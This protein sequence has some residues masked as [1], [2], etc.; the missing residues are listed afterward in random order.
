MDF[1]QNQDVARKKTGVLV[2][3]F[4]LAVVVIIVSVYVA[5]AAI[6]TWSSTQG[7]HGSAPGL[8]HLWDPALFG[9]VAV[10]VSGLV[11]GGSL[12]KIAALSGGGHT[13]AELLGGRLLNPAEANGP[14]ERKILNVVE[15]MAIASGVPVPPVYLLEEEQG[16][17]AFAAGHAPGDAVIAV[18]SGC[19]RHLSRD[20]LQGVVAHE[21][22]HIL[23]GDMRLNIRLMGVLFGILLI[24]LTG[25]LILRSTDGSSRND[26]RKEGK[27]VLPFIGL[28]LYIIGYS[29]V[30]FGNLIKA[31][32]SRQREFLADASAV[33][34]TRNPDGI[35]GALKKIG[36]LS[37]GSKIEN[38][39]AEEASHLFFGSSGEGFGHFLG[40]LATHPP[41]V[42]R[43]R[44]IDPSFDGD[45]SAVQLTPIESEAESPRP[46]SKKAVSRV[47]AFNPVE[48]I[49]KIGTI[50]PAQLA[51]AAGLLESL[52][53]PLTEAVRDPLSAQAVVFALLL[54]ADESV[55]G[56]QLG[57]LEQHVLPASVRETRMILPEVSRLAPE[58]RLPLVELAAPALRR[59]TPAQLHDFLR[60]VDV[61]IQADQETTL[62]EYALQRLLYQHVVSLVTKA[63]PPAVRFTTAPS[64]VG[65]VSV[66]LSALARV[67]HDTPEGV[68]R[69]FEVGAQ[70]LGWRDATPSPQFEAPIG[71]PEIDV[72]LG[73]LAAASPTLKKQVLEGCASCI[74]ADGRVSVKEGEML[75]AISD[76]LG[77]PMPPLLASAEVAS[78]A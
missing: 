7:K 65:P 29:G 1:F 21:F 36:A 46:P 52:S 39:H 35:A 64:L 62:F 14:D 23:N 77:C 58:A 43:I 42:E 56:S 53:G 8:N 30:F 27:N 17:N 24:G 34:F 45:F 19:V 28:A 10:G 13:V 50:A 73:Q 15:E 75:R 2:F 66:I 25:W 51:Y 68:A 72:A 33:Q 20:E 49:T 78:H 9:L 63:K 3:Y 12:Y 74:G 67:G 76:S 26:D 55:R 31:A 18:T 32:V 57:W 5:L 47:D 37:E 70:A 16:I 38:P 61:L 71:I 69:G 22:S 60:S 54:D 41:L 44:R 48:A 6:L 40:M 11:G 59:M 4:I